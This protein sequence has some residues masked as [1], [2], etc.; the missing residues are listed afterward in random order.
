LNK[1]ALSL[2]SNV[3][4]ALM[5]QMM[6]GVGVNAEDSITVLY[7]G[8][9]YSAAKDAVDAAG[10]AGTIIEGYVFKNPPATLTLR[11]GPGV[12]VAQL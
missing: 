9:D 6:F 8:Q 3:F 12:T 2:K 4:A 10:Q 5:I 7:A 1:L 11:Y